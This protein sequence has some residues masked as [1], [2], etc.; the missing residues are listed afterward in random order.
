M[1]FSCSKQSG[2]PY[3]LMENY[4]YR[5][6]V[7][8]NENVILQSKAQLDSL[9]GMATVMGKGGQPTEIDF[10]KEVALAVVSPTTDHETKL[11]VDAIQQKGDSLIFS[12]R[13]II[14]PEK[15]SYSIQPVLM[16]KIPKEYYQGKISFNKEH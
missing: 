4:F 8:L 9:F 12:Y 10:G 14:S 6:D 5:N 7:P 3:S 11:E 15:L 2:I 13:E 16:V 1:L